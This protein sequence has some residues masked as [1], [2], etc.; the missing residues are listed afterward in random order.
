MFSRPTHYG[1]NFIGWQI[2]DTLGH[3]WLHIQDHGYGRLLYSH[4][5]SSYH[6]V[7]HPDGLRTENS[8]KGKEG[9]QVIGDF[10]DIN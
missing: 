4:H 3:M 8:Q 10:K 9:T 2:G 1:L 5:A 7:K 6:Q